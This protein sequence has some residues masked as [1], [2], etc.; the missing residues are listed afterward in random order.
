M[1]NALRGMKDTLSPESEIYAHVI[2][3]CTKIAQNY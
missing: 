3:T 1:V 2:N